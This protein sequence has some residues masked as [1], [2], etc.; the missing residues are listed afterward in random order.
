[1][2]GIIAPVIALEEQVEASGNTISQFH[3][4][5]GGQGVHVARVVREFG[6]ESVLAS[7]AGGEMAPVVRA[8]LDQYR[9]EHR[10]VAC[11]APMAAVHSLV[12]DRQERGR[13]E[14]PPPRVTRHESDNLFETASLIVLK[15]DVV[16]LSGIL[17]EGMPSDFF[18]RLVRLA[19]RHGVRTVVDLAPEFLEPAVRAR[20]TVAKPGEH[21][22][23]RLLGL[24]NGLSPAQLAQ[25]GRRL[26]AW[27]AETVVISQAAE[28]A[29][30]VGQDWAW[31]IEPP[32]LE[33]VEE[34]GAGDCMTAVMAVGLAQGW[35]MEE[36]VR[37]AVA[38]GAGKVLR[39]GLGL[40]KREVA[41]ILRD[42][43]RLTPIPLPQG[44]GAALVSNR[45]PSKIRG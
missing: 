24:G 18:A 38:A 31:Q 22:L 41:M 3:L 25:A 11:T 43:V 45:A 40:C 15:S 27:G 9:I 44:V 8:L 42:G 2:I 10:L 16:V 29:V 14:V 26:L 12:I 7:F 20:P 17:T 21:Q 4:H 39:Q 6:E 34:A 1:M 13:W 23:G 35:P 28:G 33:P 32:A 37:T 5:P 36:I 19:N 30:A